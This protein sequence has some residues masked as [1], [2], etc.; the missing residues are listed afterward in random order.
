[1]QAEEP[2]LIAQCNDC[3]YRYQLPNKHTPP[4]MHHN[5][6]TCHSI[7][8]QQ[9]GEYKQKNLHLEHLLTLEHHKNLILIEKSEKAKRERAIYR[10]RNR[11]TKEKLA[12]IKRD[13][14]T[15][16]MKKVAGLEK[17]H[18]V[19]LENMGKMVQKLN[20]ELQKYKKKDGYTGN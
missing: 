8:K 5:L 2:L 3:N 11:K 6:E 17:R 15:D 16:F 4:I 9:N 12:S 18:R 14:E 10:N 20:E 1:M 7:L 13:Y 19:E